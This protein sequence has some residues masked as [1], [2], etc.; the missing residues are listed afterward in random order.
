MEYF[1]L[2]NGV[3]IPALGTGTNTFG[4]PANNYNAPPNNDFT[5]A[6]SAIKAGYRLFDTAVSYGNEAGIGQTIAESGIPRQEFFIT[7]KIPG[8]G[9]YITSRENVRKCVTDSMQRLRTDYIDLYLIHHPWEDQTGMLRTWHALEEL[10]NEGK[11]RAIGVSNFNTLQIE[12]LKHNNKTTPAVNQVQCNPSQWNHEIIDHCKQNNILPMAWAPL[13]NMTP[14]FRAALDKLTP[15]Y[16]KTWAQIL[17]RYNVQRGICVI[18]KSHNP[19]HQAENLNI[20]DFKL[21][22]EEMTFLRRS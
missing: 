9:E 19:Q 15:K 17:L 13:K 8:R 20:F 22:E 12:L 1:T 7:T 4:K 2:N 3:K 16:S 6:I 11:L 10:M 18:P 5:P 14:Q 21:S